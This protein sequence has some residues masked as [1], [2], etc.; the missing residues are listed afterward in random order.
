LSTVSKLRDTFETGI[1]ESIVHCAALHFHVGQTLFAGPSQVPYWH[2]PVVG[3]N[4]QPR[5]FVHSR[6]EESEAQ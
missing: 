1:A 4:P 6:Q 5:A 2:V 3:Q